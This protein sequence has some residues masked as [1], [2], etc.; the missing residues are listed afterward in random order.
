LAAPQTVAV[1]DAV[2]KDYQTAQDLWRA[3]GLHVMPAV[4]A[5]G[6]NRLAVNDLNWVVVSQTPAAGERVSRD[7][8]ITATIKK[9][10]DK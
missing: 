10:T 2:G 9:Y 6:A 1:P 4:D 8:G 5:L 3:A 7:S